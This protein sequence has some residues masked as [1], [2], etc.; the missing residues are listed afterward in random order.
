MVPQY[1]VLVEG[2]CILDKDG[3]TIIGIPGVFVSKKFSFE[4]AHTIVHDYIREGQV[5]AEMEEI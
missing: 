4:E 1:K 2:L 3:E 5:F